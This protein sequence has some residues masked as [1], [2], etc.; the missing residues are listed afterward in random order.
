MSQLLYE[1]PPPDHWH[2]SSDVNSHAGLE[3][4]MLARRWHRDNFVIGN[5]D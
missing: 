3:L 4:G 1:E 5:D 2:G